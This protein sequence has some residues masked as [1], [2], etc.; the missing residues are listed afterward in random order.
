M[1][2]LIGF[3]GLFS[4]IAIPA[5]G[6]GYLAAAALNNQVWRWRFRMTLL[7]G[8]AAFFA[9]VGLVAVHGPVKFDSREPDQAPARSEVAD[10]PNHCAEKASYRLPECGWTEEKQRKQESA[11]S[12]T[13]AAEQAR[14]RYVVEQMISACDKPAA[15][16]TLDE[17]KYC[18]DP[19]M[20]ALLRR[21]IK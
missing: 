14:R 5:G 20:R 6:I 3:L 21:E 10:R 11:D 12:A 13:R 15:S 17:I 9:I 1:T 18:N 8:V 4:F 2:A 16:L 19:Q 7:T